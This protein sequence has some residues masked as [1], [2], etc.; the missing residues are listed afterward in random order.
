MKLAKTRTMSLNHQDSNN[1]GNELR[2]QNSHRASDP[3]YRLLFEA[4]QDG[5]MMVDLDS[6]RVSDLNPCLCNLLGFSQSEIVGRNI[7]ELSPLFPDLDPDWFEMMG[8]VALTGEE[9]RF[10]KEAKAMKRWFSVYAFRMDGSSSRKVAILF[11][12]ITARKAEEKAARQLN[13]WL[14]RQMNERMLQQIAAVE[15]LEAFIHSVANSLRAP[16]RHL[17]GCLCGSSA[18]DETQIFAKKK[19]VLVEAKEAEL[20]VKIKSL[21]REG[22]FKRAEKRSTAVIQEDTAAKQLRRRG[23]LS[24]LRERGAT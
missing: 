24:E 5:M 13:L 17:E 15:E 16:L 8:Q 22:A 9:V 10:D 20:A 4:A 6:G 12:D 14:E 1:N 19:H 2:L 3:C 18:K 11:T 23:H 21:E 7:G